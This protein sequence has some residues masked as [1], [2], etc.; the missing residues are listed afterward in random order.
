M[1]YINKLL[2]YKRMIGISNRSIVLVVVL[3][4]LSGLFE[5]LGIGMFYPVFQFMKQGNL[6]KGDEGPEI[7]QYIYDYFSLFGV[8][9]TM[10]T[11]LILIFMLFIF[12]QFFMYVK[13]VYLSKLQ[14]FILKKLRDGV[15]KKYLSSKVV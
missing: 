7:A 10:A 13:N 8:E 3:T 15:F 14:F 12:R 5:T 1:N 9:P 4:V 11:V 6:D 2:S